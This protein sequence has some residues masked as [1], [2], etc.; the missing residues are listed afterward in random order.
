ME[1]GI[2][3]SDDHVAQ[4]R[5][6]LDLLEAGNKRF[7]LTRIIDRAHA[8]LHHIADALTLLPLIPSTA[9]RLADVGSGGGVPGL[10]LAIV[11]P[12][13]HCT[14]I[15]STG[16]KAAF[17][18]ETVQEIGLENVQVMHARAEDAALGSHRQSFDV[19]TARAVATLDWLLEFCLPLAR[20]GGIVL[21]MKG[22]KAATELKSAGAILHR[23]GGGTPKTHPV[24][25]PGVDQHVIIAVPKVA[26]TPRNLPRAPSLAKGKPLS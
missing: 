17:L 4:L 25:L 1:A 3:L 18:Q 7:N 21:A 22:A 12:Q 13:L 19:V 8:E 2:S 15:E 11:I 5:R 6:Y 26:T 9:K 24:R 20:V 16:K 14:L 23:L 10:V